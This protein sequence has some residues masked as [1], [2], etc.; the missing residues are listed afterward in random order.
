M[1]GR[2]RA[3]PVRVSTAGQKRAKERRDRNPRRG[4]AGAQTQT[5]LSGPHGGPRGAELA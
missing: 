3:T 5:Q 1:H 2:G 4:R